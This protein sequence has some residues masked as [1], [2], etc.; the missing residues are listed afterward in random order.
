VNGQTTTYTWDDEDRLTSQTFPDGHTDSYVYNGLGLRVG[1][2]DS[3]GTYSYLCAG[4]SAGSPVLWDGQAVYTAGLSERRGGVSSFYDFDRLGNLWTVDGSA[5]AVQ[6]YYQDTT[7][8]GGVIAAAGNVGTPFRFGGGNGCQTDADTGLVLM[9]HRYYDTRIGRF[10]SQDPAGDGDNWYAYADNDPVD[11][12]DP[13]GLMSAPTGAGMWSINGGAMTDAAAIYGMLGASGHWM[14]HQTGTYDDANNVT[15]IEGYNHWVN[16]GEP[17]LFDGV[18]GAFGVGFSAVGSAA[19]FHLWDGGAARHDPSFGVSRGL[20][21][22]GVAA[23]TSALGAVAAVGRGAEGTVTLYR[24][25]STAERNDIVASGTFRAGGNSSV[26]GKW[27]AE[28]AEDANTW[29]MKM[30]KGDPYHVVQAK[31]PQSIAAKMMRVGPKYDNIG[32]A[33]FAEAEHLAHMT[34]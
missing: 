10:I 11:A 14:F 4:A 18:G 5:G 28:S 20:A 2:Q 19:S 25:V 34:P 24:A 16:D 27:F 29:G 13:E 9:G 32:W 23:G 22:V 15:H 17:G 26:F 6:L 12:V 1:K 30:Y 31:A 21:D 8:F 33:R 7:G 3:T